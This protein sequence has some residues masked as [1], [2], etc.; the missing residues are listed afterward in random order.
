MATLIEHLGCAGESDPLNRYSA[1]G[2]K[3]RAEVRSAGSA[4]RREGSWPRPA[5]DARAQGAQASRMPAKA[6]GGRRRPRE[7]AAASATPRPN[8]RTPEGRWELSLLRHLRF[9]WVSRGEV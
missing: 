2:R 6:G 4:G 3:A 9:C 8:L 5:G 7:R 1:T